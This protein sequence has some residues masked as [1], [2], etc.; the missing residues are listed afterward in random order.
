MGDRILQPTNRC[1]REGWKQL[2]TGVTSPSE[3]QISQVRCETK[4]ACRHRLLHPSP[5]CALP[6][7][8]LRM[9]PVLSSS[10]LRRVG[11]FQPPL[12]RTD[13]FPQPPDLILGVP[14]GRRSQELR[15]HIR[16]RDRMEWPR[17][18]WRGARSLAG[19]WQDL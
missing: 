18:A 19:G 5:P 4:A 15:F 7:P 8:A 2:G 13:L 3:R 11:E 10:P 16:V 6:S 14:E 17:A 1:H 12:L 9:A